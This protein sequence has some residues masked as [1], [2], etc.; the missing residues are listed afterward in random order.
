M[1]RN[2]VFISL[3]K[4]Q[5]TKPLILFVKKLFLLLP[6]VRAV[7]RRQTVSEQKRRTE[8]D[9]AGIKPDYRY[10]GAST[11]NS[12]KSIMRR[13]G[14]LATSKGVASI[15]V[16]STG[17]IGVL[18]SKE[19]DSTTKNLARAKT[20]SP[21]STDTKKMQSSPISVPCGGIVMLNRKMQRNKTMPIR[22]KPRVV[23]P[24]KSS[25]IPILHSNDNIILERSA[26]MTDRSKWKGQ[27][28][29]FVKVVDLKCGINPMSSRLRKLG[30]S[31][32]SESFS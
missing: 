16:G 15:N 28:C 10:I 29:N 19:L 6:F 3:S 5:I 11:N 26:S 2:F 8:Q 32:L 27:N 24:R 7:W 1:Q 12:K 20:S 17:T 18:M 13:E 23:N 30:F 14:D 22:E 9:F 25:Q 21:S 4:L 31:K